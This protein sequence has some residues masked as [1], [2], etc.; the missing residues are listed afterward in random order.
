MVMPGAKARESFA[1]QVKDAADKIGGA[2]MAALVIAVAAIVVAAAA[3]FVSARA[4]R[5]VAAV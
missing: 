2:V 5:K 3:L 1:A 4:L